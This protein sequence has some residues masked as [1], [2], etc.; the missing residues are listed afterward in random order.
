MAGSRK[1]VGRNLGVP[2]VSVIMADE[3]G[4]EAVATE[5]D[6]SGHLSD[7]LLD[8]GL[9]TLSS[10]ITL[11]NGEE[12]GIFLAMGNL[13][14]ETHL[15]EVA[16]DTFVNVQAVF[17]VLGGGSSGVDGH[18]VHVSPVVLDEQTSLVLLAFANE[19][20]ELL[21]G[22]SAVVGEVETD[23]L[24]AIIDDSDEHGG[25]NTNCVKRTLGLG[26]RV[27]GRRREAARSL[28][29]TA[30]E[31]HV[32][33]RGQV[34]AE[35]RVDRST[36]LGSDEDRAIVTPLVGDGVQGLTGLNS[37]VSVGSLQAPQ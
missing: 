25:S 5:Q 31:E 24:L 2:D 35:A 32:I 27:V 33:L 9:L 14:V 22:G 12:A 16:S 34:V 28:E 30:E 13:L 36:L 37:E 18:V 23:S 1:V 11:S 20:L 3:D 17:G 15:L 4:S 8:S 29:G 19:A 6:A 26:A 10:A 7:D 21:G